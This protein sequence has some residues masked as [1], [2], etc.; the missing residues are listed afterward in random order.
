[1]NYPEQKVSQK[2]KHQGI[3]KRFQ[4]TR[5][6]IVIN[7]ETLCTSMGKQEKWNGR[8]SG[9]CQSITYVFAN[10]CGNLHKL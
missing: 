10:N 1:M 2:L 4:D 5:T 7:W 6:L 3:N 8:W 9:S